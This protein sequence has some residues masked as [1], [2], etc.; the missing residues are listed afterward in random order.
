[1]TKFNIA[2]F[3][4]FFQLATCMADTPHSALEILGFDPAVRAQDDLFVAANGGWLKA[5]EI[6]ADKS[7]AYGFD[8]PDITAGRV[9]SIVEDLASKPQQAASAEQKVGEFYASYL[10]TAAIDQAGLTPVQAML[11]EID[12]IKNRKELAYWQG[13][14]QGRIETPLWL[15]VF[16]DFK[17]PGINEVMTWQGG[18]GLPDRDYYLNQKDPRLVKAHAAYQTYLAKLASLAGIPHADAVAQRV[19]RLEQRIAQS[20]WAQA[21]TND[22]S[23]ISHPMTLQKLITSAPG[24]DWQAFFQ[25]ANLADVKQINV[26]QLNTATTIAALFAEIPLDDWKLYFKL[27]SL[28]EAAPVLPT[29]FRAAHFVYRGTALQGITIEPA[30]W[31]QSIDALNTALGEEV[32]QLYVAR[33]FPEEQKNRMLTMVNNLL[34]AYRESIKNLSWMTPATKVLALDKLAKI[35]SKIGYPDHWRDYSNLQIDASDAVGNRHRSARFEWEYQAAKVDHKVDHDEW[36]MTA[37]TVDA[38]YDPMGNEIIFPAGHLQAPYFDMNADDAVNY[39]AIGSMIGHEI[40]HGFD[41]QGSQFDGDGV[42]RDWWSAADHQAFEELTAKLVAQYDAEE[43]LPGKHVDGKLTLNENIA[44]LSGLQVAYLA[45]QNSLGGKPAAL[46]DGYTGEQRFFL[47]YA[48]S[49][50]SKV[51][52][53]MQLQWLTTD[54]HAPHKFR[55]NDPARNTDSFHAAFATKPGDRMYKPENER[56][57]IW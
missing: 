32:G 35:K 33:Y 26:T 21:D 47:S 3:A 19:I 11:T 40:S 17:N 54:P 9:R 27:R 43:A 1:M 42:M 5:T 7:A 2:G 14:M 4:L 56:I 50:R 23:K 51:R 20:H 12:A 15:R 25:G 31:Q 36:M 44:D 45:Y 52:E 49:W 24:F 13:R 37:Q 28:D 57:H 48:Q 8:L 41:S 38:Y 29:A 34:A 53:Q 46:I 22:P 39:G 6:P 16:P 55:A 18:L 30:R 10:N